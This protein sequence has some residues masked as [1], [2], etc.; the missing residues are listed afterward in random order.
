[1]SDSAKQ[2]IHLRVWLIWTSWNNTEPVLSAHC[3]STYHIVP[4]CCCPL[5][6]WYILED[7]LDNLNQKL[8]STYYQL[9][10]NMLKE[11]KMNRTLIQTSFGFM[12]KVSL[13]REIHALSKFHKQNRFD[14]FHTQSKRWQWQCVWSFHISNTRFWWIC[15]CDHFS[16]L[17]GCFFSPSLTLD[18]RNWQYPSSSSLYLTLFPPVSWCSGRSHEADTQSL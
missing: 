10:G 1:M 3:T 5:R 9:L 12:C 6:E 18:T 11:D 2:N 15:W 17:C 14:G 13:P 4:N 7:T 8:R 16:W